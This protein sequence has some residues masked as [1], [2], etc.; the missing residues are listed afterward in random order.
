MAMLD[1]YKNYFPA[2]LNI[3]DAIAAVSGETVGFTVPFVEGVNLA[4]V[5]KSD[6][7]SFEVKIYCLKKIGQIL[8][9]FKNYACHDP[10]KGFLL[11]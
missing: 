2:Y 8:E 4:T 5:L 10:I 1:Y 6:A 3:P 7:V 9:E 11:E